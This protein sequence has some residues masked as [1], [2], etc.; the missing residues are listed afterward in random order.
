M[1]REKFNV[2]IHMGDVS[3]TVQVEAS[4]EFDAADSA[5]IWAD[6]H[7]GT[8]FA[9]FDSDVKGRLEFYEPGCW[10]EATPCAG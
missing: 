10:V 6:R 9:A 4:D 1:S 7:L 2:A 5:K 8:D 3:L